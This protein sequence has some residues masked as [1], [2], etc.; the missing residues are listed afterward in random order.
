MD[1]FLDSFLWQHPHFFAIAWMYKED[2][3]RGGF[4]MLPVVEP[5]GKRTFRQIL[6]HSIVLIQSRCYR[7]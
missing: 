4:K 1:S 6:W 5:D 3:E 2:Y 7:R